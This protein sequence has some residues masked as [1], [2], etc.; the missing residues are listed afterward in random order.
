MIKLSELSSYTEGIL[1]YLVKFDQKEVNEGLQSWDPSWFIISKT[2]NSAF[3]IPSFS[4]YGEQLISKAILN[5]GKKE[6]EEKNK[7]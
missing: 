2:R 1:I 4:G 6:G 3:E 5:K 7:K